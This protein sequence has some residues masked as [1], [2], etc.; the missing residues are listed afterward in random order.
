MSL[1]KVINT[2]LIDMT[3]LVHFSL[4]INYYN[5]V[6]LF[7]LDLNSIYSNIYYLKF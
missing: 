1:E 7:V 4:L 2:K 5:F 6:F 3:I